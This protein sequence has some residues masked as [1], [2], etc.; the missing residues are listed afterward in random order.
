MSC[1]EYYTFHLTDEGWIRGDV[2][3]CG[4]TIKNAPNGVVYL[5]ITHYSD[6][7]CSSGSIEYDR[8]DYIDESQR[9]RI[10]DILLHFPPPEI[11]LNEIRKLGFII[12]R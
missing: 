9:D 6:G 11:I 12:A 4:K 2:K 3:E 5:T 10:S 1:L 7:D 8:T